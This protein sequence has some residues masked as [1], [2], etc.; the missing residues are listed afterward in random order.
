METSN[1]IIWLRKNEGVSLAEERAGQLEKTH[2]EVAPPCVVAAGQL[3]TLAFAT[4]LE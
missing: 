3:G 1:E 2:R 4:L